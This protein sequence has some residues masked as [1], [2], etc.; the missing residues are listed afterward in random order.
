MNARTLPRWLAAT[1]LC[2]AAFAGVA[3]AAQ[4]MHQRPAPPATQAEAMAR[5]DQRFAKLDVNR[6]GQ[7]SADELKGPRA[8]RM[9]G[10]VDTDKNGAISQAEFRAAAANRFARADTDRDGT[11]EPGERQNKWSKRGGGRGGGERM[12]ARLDTDRDGAISEAEFVAGAKQRFQKM[13]T[14]GDG[15]ID[16]AEMQARRGH[17]G[18]PGMTPP[19]T[20]A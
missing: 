16:A 15:R 9:I 13:D 14:N 1:A 8:A 3:Y 7:L 12:L 18:G 5:A 10:R 6:D 19:A 20:G 17:R 11:I 2:G 4:E